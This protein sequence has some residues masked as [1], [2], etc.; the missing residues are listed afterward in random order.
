MS[1]ITKKISNYMQT[2]KVFT[3]NLLN[4]NSTEEDIEYY[5]DKIQQALKIHDYDF[6]FIISTLKGYYGINESKQFNLMS[7]VKKVMRENTEINKLI[8]FLDYPWQEDI[9]IEFVSL[10][11]QNRGNFKTSNWINILQ[12]LRGMDKANPNLSMAAS[13]KFLGMW[14]DLIK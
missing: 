5:A 8:K 6:N 13:D 11:D 1:D 9:E 10:L 3:P 2:S 12:Y 4:D 7:I 14:D